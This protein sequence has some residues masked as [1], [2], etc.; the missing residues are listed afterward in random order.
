ML[1][2]RNAEFAQ[3]L[4]EPVQ[5]LGLMVDDYITDVLLL[6]VMRVLCSL[7]AQLGEHGF[8]LVNTGTSLFL[9]QV[10]ELVEPVADEGED[11]HGHDQKGDTH[12]SSNFSKGRQFK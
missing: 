2:G 4:L 3:A 1:L 7:D 6:V 8:C 5:T 10:P 12:G 9:V 11:D